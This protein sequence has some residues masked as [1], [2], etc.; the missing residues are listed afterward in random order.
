MFV[1]MPSRKV[2]DGYKEICFPVTKDFRQQL[3][4][5]VLKEYQQAMSQNQT[6][7]LQMPDQSQEQQPAMQMGSM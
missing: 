7:S 2:G 6:D 4:D 5:A 1:S 3:H